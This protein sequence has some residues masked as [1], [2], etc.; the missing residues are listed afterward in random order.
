MVKMDSVQQ[1]SKPTVAIVSIFRDEAKYLKEWIEFHLMVGVDKFYLTN[2]LSEDNYLQVLKP[3]IDSGVVSLRHLF[4]EINSGN[5]SVSNE[6]KLVNNWIKMLNE[7]IQ[8]SKEDWVIH[9]STDEFIFPTEKS[10]IKDVLSSYGNEVGQVCVNWI[11]FGNSGYTLKEGESLIDNLKM[12]TDTD[13]LENLHVKS[14][15]R[16]E[17]LVFMPSVHFFSIKPN[18]IT[19]DATGNPSNIRSNRYET[20]QNIRETLAINHYKIRDLSW[21]KKKIEWYKMWGRTDTEGMET[22]YNDV[23]NLDIQRFVPELKN[24]LGI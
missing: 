20:N 23:E 3:Y 7:D 5:N 12:S 16:K 13:W 8:K 17:A 6:V 22:L 11:I 10:N 14:I 2:H 4:V 19:V 21:T 1:V 18:Y 24:R 15:V 9:V